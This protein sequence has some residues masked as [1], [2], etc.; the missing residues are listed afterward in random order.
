MAIPLTLTAYGHMI[1]ALRRE[2]EGKNKLS[3]AELIMAS[4]SDESLDEKWLSE[5]ELRRVHIHLAHASEATLRR[6][7]NLSGRKNARCR[8]AE[9]A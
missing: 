8:F 5:E 6:V 3:K 2:V 4:H 1:L 9:H 7:V